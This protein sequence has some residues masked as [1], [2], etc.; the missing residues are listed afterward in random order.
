MIKKTFKI[1]ILG[2][3]NMSNHHLKVLKSFKNIEIS[4]IYSRTLSKAYEKSKI[5]NI[6]NYTN[7]FKIFMQMEKYDGIV[8]IV[9]ADQISKFVKK[10]IP[11]KIPI[12]IEKPLALN[13]KDY[14]EILQLNKIYKTPNMIGLNRRYYS[15]I[16]KGLKII[17]K[18]GISSILIEGHESYWK[19]KNSKKKNIIKDNWLFA[20]SIHTLDLFLFFANSSFN[21]ISIIDKKSNIKEKNFVTT[22]KFNNN[23]IG[24]YLSFWSSP[25]QWSIKIFG[26]ENTLV[27]NPLEIGYS[28]DKNFK[29]IIIKPSKEDLIFKPGLYLQYKNF[30]KLIKTKNNSWPDVNINSIANLYK[31]THKLS[32]K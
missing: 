14:Q 2:A 9:S 22:I 11:F 16:Q 18:N 25:G 15:I 32:I 17:R 7:S 21:K 30:L 19:I 8:L 5:F 26:N 29:K 23:I 4:S 6:K 27:F 12:L 13:I 24:T 10:L 3:G 28:L 20:N 31:L 1:G